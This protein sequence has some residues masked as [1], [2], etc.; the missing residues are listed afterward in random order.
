MSRL[1]S[2]NAQNSSNRRSLQFE[3]LED[4]RLMCADG[5]G[6]GDCDCPPTDSTN[7]RGVVVVKT[8]ADGEQEQTEQEKIA[9]LLSQLRRLQDLQVTVEVRF[10]TVSDDFFERIGVDFDFNLNDG[11]PLGDGGAAFDNDPFDFDFTPPPNPTVTD[12]LPGKGGGLTFDP[13]G[14]SNGGLTGGSGGLGGL[15]G[16][17]GFNPGGGI[18][19]GSALLSDVEVFF[20]LEAA[21]QDD[22]NPLTEKKAK[23]F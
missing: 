6:G 22:D 19:V 14:G 23:M 1:A 11:L 21:Q 13:V 7:D 5:P 20:F 8:V 17:G 4:R 18:G 10:I 2:K 12:P 16:L 9:D 15:S 3:G